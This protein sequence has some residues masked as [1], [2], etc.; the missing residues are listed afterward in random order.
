MIRAAFGFV[1]VAAVMLCFAGAA[2][3]VPPAPQPHC[4]PAPESCDGWYQGDVSITWTFDP[5]WTSVSCDGTPVTGDTTG[6]SR[7]C[8]VTYASGT[9]STT[10]TIKRDATPPSVTPAAARAPDQNGWYNRRSR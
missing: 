9:V 10:I 8:S 7:T 2:G 3:A 4:S 6:V 1:V 5:G